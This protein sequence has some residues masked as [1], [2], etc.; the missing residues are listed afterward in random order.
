MDIEKKK[1]A[2]VRTFFSIQE[3]FDFMTND[4]KQA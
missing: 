2:R 1:W 3:E 4:D